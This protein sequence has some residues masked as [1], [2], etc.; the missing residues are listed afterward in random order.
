MEA[1]KALG[2]LARLTAAT[3]SHWGPGP[4]EC[5]NPVRVCLRASIRTCHVPALFKAQSNV[6]LKLERWILPLLLSVKR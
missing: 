1:V 3:H 5:S 6:G 4:L 2:S